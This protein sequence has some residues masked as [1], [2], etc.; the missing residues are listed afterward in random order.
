MAKGFVGAGDGACFS[1]FFF[2]DCG[3][4]DASALKSRL[5]ISP[6]LYAAA[7]FAMIKTRVVT[8]V[9]NHKRWRTSQCE[10]QAEQK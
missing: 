3:A 6:R 8:D 9:G 5:E 4:A 7:A 2:L 1:C 10:F